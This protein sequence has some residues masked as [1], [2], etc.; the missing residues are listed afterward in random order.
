MKPCIPHVVNKQLMD[1]I[2]VV[3]S[4]CRERNTI[5]ALFCCLCLE[6]MSRKRNLAFPRVGIF[7]FL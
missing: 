5:D 4:I 3:Y 1:V 6:D 2:T 7:F